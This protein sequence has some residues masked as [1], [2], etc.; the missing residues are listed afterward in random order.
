MG[1]GLVAERHVDAEDAILVVRV[2]LR[3]VQ[4]TR[5]LD[6][7]AELSLPPLVSVHGARHAF[8]AAFAAELQALSLALDWSEYKSYAQQ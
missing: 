7:A 5:Q 4:L 3:R 1:L 6:G 2:C 8:G